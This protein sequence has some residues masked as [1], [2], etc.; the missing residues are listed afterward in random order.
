MIRQF[1]PPFSASFGDIEDISKVTKKI[2]LIEGYKKGGFPLYSDTKEMYISADDTHCGVAG[3]TGSKK[4]RSIMFNTICNI[5]GGEEKS[6]MIIH[7]T[8]GNVSEYTYD[9]LKKQGYDVY[10]IN[11]R[12]PERSDHCNILDFVTLSYSKGDIK[13][14]E[15]KLG[16]IG[17]QLISPGLE[18]GKDEYW[19]TTSSTYHDGLF[20]AVAVFSGY[21][22]KYINYNNI[23]SLHNELTKGKTFQ[24]LVKAKLK[25]LGET[26][27]IN[28]IDSVWGNALDTGK[29]LI[30]MINNPFKTLQSVSDILY[31]SDFTAED[32]VNKPTCVFINTPDES[33]EFNFIVSLLIKSLYGEFIDI[34]SGCKGTTL[35]HTLYFLIDEFGALPEIE[36]FDSII[37]A[38]RS[39]NIRFL[40]I[41]Q[42]FAQIRSVYSET[43]ALN[44]LNNLGTTICFRSNDYEL[45]TILRKSI[46]TR[47]L[48]YSN[49]EIEVIPPGTLRALKKGESVILA[50]GVK[51]PV[52]VYYPDISE[53]PFLYQ[54]SDCLNRKRKNEVSY[55]D[56]NDI[57]APSDKKKDNLNSPT[58]DNITKSII[59]DMKERADFV[60]Q[61]NKKREYPFIITERIRYID[62][63]PFDILVEDIRFGKEHEVSQH[64]AKIL[65]KPLE[66]AVVYVYAIYREG[67]SLLIRCQN[68]K[69]F[70]QAYALLKDLCKVTVYYPEGRS[71]SGSPRDSH[72]DP[73]ASYRDDVLRRFSEDD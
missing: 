26:E 39:R 20:K 50:Q 67:N 40:L 59:A 52:K 45:E 43:G 47:T 29:N 61:L 51:N 17:K 10:I 32:I 68:K 44:I 55:F 62:K 8:K 57:L 19:K 24:N 42:T 64:F 71:G 25:E 11:F 46:G 65:H 38:S 72:F 37:S 3:T 2:N 5:A 66:D 21:D 49:R 9:Y 36:D 58:K 27:A 53:H 35:P 1:V 41:F 18:A 22:K 28:N 73:F 60:A 54:S 48:P 31:K 70:A 6:S 4:T 30:T 14:A 33:K 69:Q 34:A 7:D 15:R 12:D 13:K 16:D 23:I 56:W 63:T